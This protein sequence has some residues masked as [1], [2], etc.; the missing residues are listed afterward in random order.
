MSSLAA[1]SSIRGRFTFMEKDCWNFWMSSFTL[2]NARSSE[3]RFKVLARS[4]ERALQEVS[5]SERKA[6]K[7]L[8][9]SSP[10]ISCNLAN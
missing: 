2:E 5:R 7:L 10:M 8:V 4:D 3:W 9:R 6:I 1:P